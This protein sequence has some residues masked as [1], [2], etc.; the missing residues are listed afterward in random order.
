MQDAAGNVLEV[1]GH[2]NEDLLVN[3]EGDLP[4]AERSALPGP[5]SGSERWM[6]TRPRFTR[7]PFSLGILSCRTQEKMIATQTPAGKEPEVLETARS[8]KRLGRLN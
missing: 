2:D 5:P 6:L 1:S 7:V 8:G 4:E 3:C